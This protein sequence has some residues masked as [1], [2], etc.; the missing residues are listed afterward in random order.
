MS[1][2]FLF[3][4]PVLAVMES[5]VALTLRGLFTPYVFVLYTCLFS[6]L[7]LR[8]VAAHNTHTACFFPPFIPFYVLSLRV[9]PSGLHFCL[10]VFV[11]VCFFFWGGRWH[12]PQLS[13]RYVFLYHTPLSCGLTSLVS[14]IL[15]SSVF[16]LSP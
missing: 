6:S 4:A 9:L 2:S 7:T 10:F 11:F 5:R 3:L 14:F 1:C 8:H 13:M 16:R 12:F 15:S